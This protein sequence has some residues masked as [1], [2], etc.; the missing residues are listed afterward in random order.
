MHNKDEIYTRIK[1]VGKGGGLILGPTHNVQN[2][3]SIEKVE[4]FFNYARKIGSY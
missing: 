1:T 2:D 3:T 4:V